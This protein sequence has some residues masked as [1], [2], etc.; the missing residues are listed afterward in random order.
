MSKNWPQHRRATPSAS[1]QAF[2]DALWRIVGTELPDHIRAAERLEVPL[3][4][5][6][7]LFECR[8]RPDPNIVRHQGWARK[9]AHHYGE[10]WQ[11]DGHIVVAFAPDKRAPI[12]RRRGCAGDPPRSRSELG[13]ALGAIIGK[14]EDV[15]RVAGILG[16]NRL[17]M[18]QILQ[19]RLS[20]SFATVMSFDWPRRLAMH[21]PEGWS[22]H[23][24]RFLAAL[25]E[26]RRSR[27]R[28]VGRPL[29]RY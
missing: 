23:G 29:E 22:L 27:G 25:E 14:Y 1:Q 15:N 9:L 16:C 19:G 8:R 10:G 26:L 21:Y 18:G 3:S 11:A 4:Y 12:R 13:S 6:R 2:L 28:R 17:A 5:I 20:P 24:K 7:D